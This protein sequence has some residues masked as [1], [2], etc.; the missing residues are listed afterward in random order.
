MSWDVF[1]SHA[2]EDKEDV[3]R[4]LYKLLTNAGLKVWID[5]T[6]ITIGDSLRKK[7]D[8]GLLKSNYG[9]VILSPQF[10]AKDWPQLELDGL[11]SRE[12]GGRPKVILPVWHNVNKDEV[13]KYSPI[14]ASKFAGNTSDGLDKVALALQKAIKPA[15]SMP[16]KDKTLNVNKEDKPKAEINFL[17]KY[18]LLI[19]SVIATF[20]IIFML[21]RSN[22]VKTELDSK[23]DK[24]TS[25]STSENENTEPNDATTVA[26]DTTGQYDRYKS[27]INII[28][29]LIPNST[30]GYEVFTNIIWS[31]NDCNTVEQAIKINKAVGSSL[32]LLMAKTYEDDVLVEESNFN[33]RPIKDLILEI[34]QWDEDYNKLANKRKSPCKMP[35]FAPMQYLMLRGDLIQLKDELNQ[36]LSIKQS[37]TLGLK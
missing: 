25:T 4:P 2:S 9:I 17:S 36:R 27:M 19:I 15:G 10:F 22:F 1:I 14:L 5:E 12:I 3:V 35:M 16:I 23:Q 11:I 7:I 20:I 24:S 31:H 21:Y 33:I 6:E 28:N 32:K 37:R 29:E 18:R 13:E 8:E 34:D 30:K 26:I